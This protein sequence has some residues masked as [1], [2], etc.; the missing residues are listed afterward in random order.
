[1]HASLT[2]FSL[3]DATLKRYLEVTIKARSRIDQSG[4]ARENVDDEAMEFITAA[5]GIKMLCRY[6]GQDD[7]ERILE[8]SSTVETWLARIH[9]DG[10]PQSSK[11]AHELSEELSQ[12]STNPH[13]IGPK[14]GLVHGYFAVGI[15]RFQQA[16]LT[17]DSEKRSAIFQEAVDFLQLSISPWFGLENNPGLLHAFARVNAGIRDTDTAI[18]AVKQA[19]VTS[20]PTRLSPGFYIDY[21]D[22]YLRCWH[23]LALLLSTEATPYSYSKAI[24]SCEAG[25]DLYG[26]KGILYGN[27]DFL[28]SV[29]GLSLVEKKSIVEVKIT[30]LAILKLKKGALA[31]VDSSEQLL[32]LYAKLFKYAEERPVTPKIHGNL[33]LAPPST[34]NGT[35]RSFRGSILGLPLHRGA[36]GKKKETST[37]TTVQSQHSIHDFS[38]VFST[39][40]QVTASATN[41]ESR[42]STMIRPGSKRLQKRSSHIET[43]PT[44]RPSTSESSTQQPLNLSLP[45]RK[46]QST[47]LIMD[48]PSGRISPEVTPQFNADE[49]GIA[50]SHDLPS[51]PSSPTYVPQTPKSLQSGSPPHYSIPQPVKAPAER[52]PSPVKAAPCSPIGPDPHF[53][54]QDEERHALTLLVKIWLVIVVLYREANMLEEA[55]KALEEATKTVKRIETS[56]VAGEGGSAANFAKRGLGGVKS[57][58]ELHADV[59]GVQAEMFEEQGKTAKAKETYQK[60]L[61]YFPDHVDATIGFAKMLLDEYKAAT[62]EKMKPSTEKPLQLPPVLSTLPSPKKSPNTNRRFSFFSSKDPSDDDK[63]RIAARDH[64]HGL[65][66]RLTQ[67]GTGWDCGEAWALMADVHEASGMKDQAIAANEWVV[68][69]ETERPVRPYGEAT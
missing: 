29:T 47:A 62:K 13:K 18:V 69:L 59:L 60:A 42:L 38:K 11:S 67:S 33:S 54:R 68:E 24:E 34:P 28:D 49:V 1:M 5:S 46:T 51:I 31:A 41:A 55:E 52:P 44:K 22:V 56:I 9:P 20:K 32:A 58:N 26:S 66:S 12:W 25:L 14:A 40:N 61:G 37:Q 8:I 23:L 4:T 50:I 21:R 64:A 63:D 45:H 36:Q 48:T 39:S 3:A 7:I 15:S 57:L 65:L 53:S 19:L 30:H 6:G 27:V 17:P 35:L 2:E 16:Q 10:P 43:T